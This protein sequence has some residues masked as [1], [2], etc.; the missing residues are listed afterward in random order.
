MRTTATMTFG[1]GESFEQRVNHLEVVRQLQEETGGFTAFT[2]VSFQP[3]KAWRE[4]L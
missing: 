1:V 4:R 3:R 2:P